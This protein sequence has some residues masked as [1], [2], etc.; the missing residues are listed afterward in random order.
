MK[1]L[2]TKNLFFCLL[3][4]SVFSFGQLI[5]N[6][7]TTNTANA[8]CVI[9]DSN[10]D[11]DNCDPGEDMISCKAD[12]LPPGIPTLS[13]PEVLDNIT[14]WIL[15]FGLLIS[16]TFLVWGGINYVGSSGDQQKAENS[17]KIIKYAILG[18][19]VIGLSYAAIATIDLIF[20]P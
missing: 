2:T 16:V 20:T 13:I 3:I 11:G 5:I 4:L 12:C 1:K 9:G 18:V 6:L 15:G 19:L 8:I 14:G 7:N 10:G 17:K